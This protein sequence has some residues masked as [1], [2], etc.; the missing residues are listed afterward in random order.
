MQL[1]TFLILY[2][3]QLGITVALFYRLDKGVAN[4]LSSLNFI[5][6]QNTKIMALQDQLNSIVA[7]LQADA[8]GM[9]ADITAISG[10]V[11]TIST[12]LAALI[13][14]AQNGGTVDLT[15]LQAVQTQ[16]DSAK[17]GLDTVA[18]SVA[19][20]VPASVI[21]ATATAAPAS[22]APVDPAAASN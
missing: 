2:T 21:P 5:T 3:L 17:S 20:L 6:S 1:Y 14:A 15:G 13:A 11:G 7:D 10:N 9:A 12:N 4:V 16:L 22:P 8:A 18:A 19:G